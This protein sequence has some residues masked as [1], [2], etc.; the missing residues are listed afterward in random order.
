MIISK[1][2]VQDY[3]TERFSFFKDII[4]QKYAQEEK[5]G[6]GEPQ[7]WFFNPSR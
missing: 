7:A 5:L 3:G 2:S 6:S 4:I 1:R